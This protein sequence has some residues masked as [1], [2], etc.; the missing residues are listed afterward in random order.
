MPGGY[1][2][3]R[4]KDPSK[5]STK[6]EQIRRRLRRGVNRDQDI[7]LYAEHKPGFKPL[8]E[9]DLEEL[10]HGYPRNR[11][12]RFGGHRPTWITD[13]MVKEAKKRLV[14][15]ATGKLTSH[16][17]LAIDTVVAIIESEDVDDKGRP[18]VD[19]RTRLD[20]AKFI[21]EHVKGKP[22]ALV[23]IEAADFTKRMLAAAIVLDDGKPQDAP[24]VL[25]GEFTEEEDDDDADGE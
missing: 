19:A 7:A 6:P 1:V 5:L 12:G 2:G 15:Q 9:W 17:K 8:A 11:A 23:E 20:A 18:I 24:I 10:A 22:T 4:P 16:V 14:E 13:A 21:I 25:D 3:G